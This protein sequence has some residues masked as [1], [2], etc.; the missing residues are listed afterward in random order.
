MTHADLP[1]TDPSDEVDVIPVPAEELERVADELEQL[2]DAHYESL[3]RLVEL[4]TMLDCVLDD[5]LLRCAVLGQDMTIVAISRGMVE[6][7]GL[8]DDVIGR[9]WAS[10]APDEWSELPTRLTQLSDDGSWHDIDGGGAAW[11]VRHCALDEGAE[12][13]Y[14]LRVMES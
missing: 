12:P 11:S 9:P 2:A 4:E 6:V 14:V 1:G 3:A 8:A 10:V 13:V 7:L 5:P